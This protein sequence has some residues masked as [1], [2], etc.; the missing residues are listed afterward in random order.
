MNCSKI[1]KNQKEM[2]LHEERKVP[3]RSKETWAASGMKET[4]AGSLTLV[5]NKASQNIRRTI[6][7]NEKKWITIHA[8]SRNGEELAVPISKAVTTMLRHFHQDERQTD[9]SRHWDS[10]KSVLV[11]KFANEGA[12][13]VSD[14]AWLQKI[15]AGSTKKRIEF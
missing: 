3:T 6:H 5:P 7:T 11:R 8:H 10:I 12:R 13:D 9:G 4:R 1:F 2:N 14:E 15:F